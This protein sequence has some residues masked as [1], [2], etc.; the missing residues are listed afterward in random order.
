MAKFE[1]GQSGNPNGRPKKGLAFSD[2]LCDML[3][4]PAPEAVVNELFEYFGDRMPVICSRKDA[5][6]LMRIKKALMGDPYAPQEL[7]NRAYGTPIQKSES[8]INLDAPS[9]IRLIL[10]E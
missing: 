7:F 8:D 9:G 4:E 3:D 5:I 1:K 2:A 10:G 6:L